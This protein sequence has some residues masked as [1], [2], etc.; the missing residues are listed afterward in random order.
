MVKRL[1]SR[2]LFCEDGA[3]L[4]AEIVLVG[5]VLVLG[6][7]TG[8]SCL[9]QSLTSELQ[10]LAGAFGALDQSYCFS[11]HAKVGYCDRICA[12]N[13]GSCFLDAADRAADADSSAQTQHKVPP[14]ITYDARRHQG[15]PCPDCGRV[16]E[17]PEQAGDRNQERPR[18]EDNH[19]QDRRP[20]R[21][22]QNAERS[23]SRPSDRRPPMPESRRRPGSDSSDS[24]NAE[25][26][27][28][29]GDAPD[30]QEDGRREDNSRSSRR[31][32]DSEDKDRDDL[33]GEDE[34]GNVEEDDGDLQATRHRNPSQ[35]V[36]TSYYSA[37]LGCD[38][39]R[40]SG[41]DSCRRTHGCSSCGS[42]RP[43]GACR[44]CGGSYRDEYRSACGRCGSYRCGGCGDYSYGPHER[45]TNVRHMR[46]SEW[47]ISPGTRYFPQ[48]V[49][50]APN[51]PFPVYTPYHGNH[52][53]P[54]PNGAPGPVPPVPHDGP[55]SSYHPQSGLPPHVDYAMP[56]VPGA[57]REFRGPANHGHMLTPPGHYAHDQFA[58][59]PVPQGP[60]PA[61]V[62]DHWAPRPGSPHGPVPRVD[63]QWTPWNPYAG[64]RHE[65]RFPD[66]VW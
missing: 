54:M 13:S 27:R 56:S 18:A 66:Y 8:L 32:S 5:T 30:A 23:E 63:Y 21:D 43:E 29:S 4:S 60:V 57:P 16:H 37:M 61:G 47:P 9:Q 15:A 51:P 52:H 49:G 24:R 53:G 59:A 50:Y 20:V 55:A 46:V 35:Y 11:G 7:V 6:L 12:Y 19:G 22:P 34:V 65:P 28:E 58:P 14:F 44:T 10:D 41:C 26:N 42:S 39:C 3:I 1:F 40:E 36:L 38:R 2:W 17:H 33:D 64:N 31:R 25:S 48:Q 62:Q 45:C